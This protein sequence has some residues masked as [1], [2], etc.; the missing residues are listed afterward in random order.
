[1]SLIG[2]WYGRSHFSKNEIPDQKS[3][4]DVVARRHSQTRG[5]LGSGGG[6][7]LLSKQEEQG[8]SALLDGALLSN[9]VQR[10]V[11][12]VNIVMALV[13]YVDIGTFDIS[14]AYMKLVVVH[15]A[16][17]HNSNVPSSFRCNVWLTS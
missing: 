15:D 3:F 11:L 5:Y 10:L 16:R 8:L 2:L 13:V 4:R 17:K 9:L 6:V 1:V 14:Q 7:L 12:L